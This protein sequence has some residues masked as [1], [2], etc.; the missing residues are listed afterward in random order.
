MGGC[1]MAI[2]PVRGP[3]LGLSF[4]FCEGHRPPFKEELTMPTAVGATSSAV[5]SHFKTVPFPGHQ[6]CLS[7][8]AKG[9][10]SPTPPHFFPLK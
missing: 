9:P 8:L 6:I 7:A 3:S 4:G 1:F 5:E 10:F 2:T